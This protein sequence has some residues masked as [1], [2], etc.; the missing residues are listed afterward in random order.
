MVSKLERTAALFESPKDFLAA[1]KD[2]ALKRYFEQVL[3]RAVIQLSQTKK[4][5]I[6]YKSLSVLI[7][8]IQ[9][10]GFKPAKV[11][12]SIS[13]KFPISNIINWKYF[14]SFSE[15]E[16]LQ[17]FKERGWP[18][19]I[20]F[21][22]IF[23]P[24]SSETF[25]GQ[26]NTTTLKTKVVTNANVNS[27]EEFNGELYDIIDTIDHELTHLGQIAL[28]EFKK[29]HQAGS[30]YKKEVSS[31]SNKDYLNDDEEFYPHLNDCIKAFNR[32]SFK[33][34]KSQEESFKQWV[35][36]ISD[37]T[38]PFFKALKDKEPDKWRKAIKEAYKSINWMQGSF[39]E[40]EP[41]PEL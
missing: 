35:G 17:R 9:N 16:I 22:L 28:A 2:W 13:T 6:V 1:M 34:R 10:R 40:P 33:S 18:E 38:E 37:P 20:G 3:G 41:E 25:M 7:T 14:S 21:A 27:I 5:T 11:I 31:N 19:D 26:F 39:P 8:A 36:V 15:K 12:G 23:N 32:H 29:L 4:D 30:V 24:R